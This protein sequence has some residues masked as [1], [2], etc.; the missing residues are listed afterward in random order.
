[1]NMDIA[2]ELKSFLDS[3]NL[4]AA[5]KIVD[6]LDPSSVSEPSVARLAGIVLRNGNQREK[7]LAF[8]AR[9][10]ELKPDDPEALLQMAGELVRLGQAKAGEELLRQVQTVEAAQLS[11]GLIRSKARYQQRDFKGAEQAARDLLKIYPGSGAGKLELAHAL[12]MQGQWLEGWDAYEGRYQMPATRD[13]IPELGVP[14]WDGRLCNG[15]LILI[16]DQGYGDCFMF[17]RYIPLA[18]KR[19]KKVTLMRSK[20]LGPILDSV[21]GVGHGIGRW[22]ELKH[23][24]T[25]CTLSGLPRLFTTEPD[26]I[27]S[28]RGLLTVPEPTAER[29]QTRLGQ[30]GKTGALKVGLAW[31]G[32][33]NFDQNSLRA[34]PFQELSPLLDR[35]QAQFFSLQVGYPNDSINDERLIDLSSELTDFAETA[36]AMQALDLVI[37]TDTSVAHLAGTLG[38]PTWVLTSYAPDWRWGAEGSRNLW[39]PDSLRL[40]RQQEP[41]NWAPVVE[42]AASLLDQA[43]ADPEPAA[44]AKALSQA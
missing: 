24:S 29:W 38:V 15:P 8:A 7:A 9:A 40:L 28:C 39:Y 14:A 35:Q 18:A 20:E 16:A 30:Q 26:S 3:G 5:L 32:R 2:G 27:P 22:E 36:A 19:C 13:V 33:V 17:A 31:S 37:T 1:M 10:G 6:D 11:S 4:G 34:I 44:R 23:A 12:L 43:L 42:E 25:W 21:A 41:N